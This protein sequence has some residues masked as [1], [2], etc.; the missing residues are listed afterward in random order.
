MIYE[1]PAF[2]FSNLEQG[3]YISKITAK[4]KIKLNLIYS[5]NQLK[6]QGPLY[7]KD[8]FKKLRNKNIFFHVD[9]K[10]NYGNVLQIIRTDIDNI[11]FSSN[12]EIINNK[13]QNLS[14]QYKSR[15]F[16][17]KKFKKIHLMDESID[18]KFFMKEFNLHFEKIKLLK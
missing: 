4:S 18:I 10:S 6:W 13:I 11:I 12:D 2:N 17:V 5:Y 1:I 9:C 3:E 7:I 8:L 15:I 14:E 16:D